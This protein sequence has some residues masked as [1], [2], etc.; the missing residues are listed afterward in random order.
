MGQYLVFLS[1]PTDVKTERDRAEAISAGRSIGSRD[2]NDF[3]IGKEMFDERKQCFDP[4]LLLE[5]LSSNS[6]LFPTRES[7]TARSFARVPN[8][9]SKSRR[10]IANDRRLLTKWSGE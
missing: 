7:V 4:V 5:S 6:S 9:V 8:G 1:S 10:E 3:G 2:R